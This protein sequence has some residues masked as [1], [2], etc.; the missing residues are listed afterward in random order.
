MAGFERETLLERIAAAGQIQENIRVQCENLT[1]EKEIQSQK[2]D[3]LLERDACQR[4]ANVRLETEIEQER[5]QSTE[6][7]DLLEGVREQLRLQFS[8]LA[9]TILE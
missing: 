2:I 1:R 3:E 8:E 7:L 9:T 5:L 6:K 4:S